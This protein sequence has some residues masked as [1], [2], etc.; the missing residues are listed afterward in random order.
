MC[1]IIATDV[2]VVDVAY[3]FRYGHSDVMTCLTDNA[4]KLAFICVGFYVWKAKCENIKKY[5]KE[6]TPDD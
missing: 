6:N 3:A 1:M 5:G 4:F 2:A